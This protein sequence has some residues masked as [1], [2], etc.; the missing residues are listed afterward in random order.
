[1]ARPASPVAAAWGRILAVAAAA[2]AAALLA[3][4]G[5]ARWRPELARLP[6]S[7]FRALGLPR[8]D[9]E[10]RLTPGVVAYAVRLSRRF[11]IGAVA[12]LSGGFSG[13]GLEAQLAAAAPFPGRVAVFMN[14]D[15]AGC[16]GPEWTGREVARLGAGRAA[17]AVG[18]ALLPDGPAAGELPAPLWAACERL[19]LPVALADG[20][21]AL[22]GARPR[23]AVLGLGF[24]GLAGD[25]AAAGAALDR[26]PN[27]RLSLGGALPRLASQGEA[28]RALLLRHSGRILFGTGIRY[29]DRPPWHELLLGEGPPVEEE[30]DLRRFYLGLYRI[31]ETRDPAIPGPTPGQPAVEGL[32]LPR[33]VLERV[34]HRN[35]RTL[36]RLGARPAAG[37]R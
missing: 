18:L 1:M 13:G 7:P 31:L 6:E 28:A 11:G 12:N 33:E 35:G 8:V 4:A 15:P 10:E 14:L 27:L 37:G 9:V 23:L 2:L 25:A 5:V 30:A 32:G 26:L 36:L 24:G 3:A 17:G 21:A 34:Y 16:C 22:A 29:Q 19:G 20:A